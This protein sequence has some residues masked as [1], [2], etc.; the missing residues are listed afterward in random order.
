[1]CDVTNPASVEAAVDDAVKSFGTPSLLWNSKLIVKYLRSIF[2]LLNM[3]NF[4][5]E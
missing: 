3:P 1:M 2:L 4:F 5:H